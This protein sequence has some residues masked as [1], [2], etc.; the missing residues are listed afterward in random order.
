MIIEQDITQ[1]RRILNSWKKKGYK[2]CLVPTM[3]YFHDG[4]LA[5]MKTALEVADKVVVSLFVNPTQFGPGEDLDNYP[6]DLEGDF[7][8][9]EKIGVDLIFCPTSEEIYRK[10]H[11]TY[12]NVSALSD[13]LCGKDRPNHFGGVTTIVT[14]LINIVQPQYVIFGEKD[15]QQLTIIRRMVKDMNIPVEVLGHPIIREPDGLAMSS[16][17]AYLDEEDRKVAVSLYNALC[18]VK[19]HVKNKGDKELATALQL[20]ERTITQHSQCS[21]DY[22]TIVDSESLKKT[23]TLSQGCRIVGAIKISGKTRLIDNMQL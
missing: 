18:Q 13:G 19:E 15:F 2:V 1:T 17:N 20:A 22:L 3:G 7:N 8:K 6:K 11:Q 21:I 5:L 12:V 4:H 10:N 9:A 23:A 16:R 14:K